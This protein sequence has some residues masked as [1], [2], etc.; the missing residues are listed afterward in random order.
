MSPIKSQKMVKTTKRALHINL[1]NIE[2][3]FL[4]HVI[5]EGDNSEG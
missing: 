1:Y 2:A 3:Y 4:K 5:S